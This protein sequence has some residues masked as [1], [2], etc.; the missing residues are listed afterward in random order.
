MT[1]PANSWRRRL[2]PR[3]FTV[4]FAPSKGVPCSQHC[5][6]CA[7]VVWVMR[8]CSPSL[9]EG[10]HFGVH[11]CMLHFEE[12]LSTLTDLAEREHALVF[13]DADDPIQ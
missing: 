4:H 9:T 7:S 5:G 13:T 12:A 3:P 6:G 8:L 10:T 11:A 2:Q 1:L